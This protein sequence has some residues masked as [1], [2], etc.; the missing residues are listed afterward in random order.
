MM[1][2]LRLLALAILWCVVLLATP[3]PSLAVD[4]DSS[5]ALLQQHSVQVGY[6]PRDDEPG[7][8]DLAEAVRNEAFGPVEVRPRGEGWAVHIGPTPYRVEAYAFRQILREQG[9]PDAFIV[10][11]PVT[12]PGAVDGLLP[13]P[14]LFAPTDPRTS[15]RG[16]SRAGTEDNP[17]VGQCLNDFRALP[18]EE[19]YASIEG[20]AASL[21][22]DDP[23]KGRLLVRA[24]RLAMVFKT[25]PAPP[26]DWLKRVASGEVACFEEDAQDA[27][28]F[29]GRIQQY[30]QNRKVEAFCIYQDAYRLWPEDSDF[31]ACVS[32]QM[33]AITLELAHAQKTTYDEARRFAEGLIPFASGREAAVLD[34][35]AGESAF[36]DGRYFDA[37]K[38]LEGF[39]DRHP[40]S[41]RE[42]LMALYFR[43]RA[44]HRA[45]MKE[46][47]IEALTRATEW[48][49][50]A[51]DDFFGDGR[52]GFMDPRIAASN[53][54]ESLQ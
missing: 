5:L 22:N 12:S 1:L 50:V 26:Y 41:R 6:F 54:L 38:H 3:F 31:L 42:V 43:G 39:E 21:D 46:T 20:L 10:S 24:S 29:Y 36:F 18:T 7:A 19:S 14:R 53:M 51:P 40:D 33:A 34:L 23:W 35:M 52:G 28:W 49:P 48:E 27:L 32:V 44:A 15:I 2:M 16:L 47:A 17:D 8:H 37:V 30:H 13:A 4:Q 25:D 11:Q 9:Y 45:G